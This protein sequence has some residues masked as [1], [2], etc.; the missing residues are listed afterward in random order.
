MRQLGRACAFVAHRA[1][2]EFVELCWGKD[3]GFVHAPE[4]RAFVSFAVEVRPGTP[5][6]RVVM[7]AVEVAEDLVFAR[8]QFMI[9]ANTELVAVSVE[10]RE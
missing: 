2:F 7:R 5:V 6:E 1:E 3:V 10:L 9:E 4:Q 8:P